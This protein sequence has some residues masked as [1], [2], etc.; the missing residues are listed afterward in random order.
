MKKHI[1]F[2]FDGT[3]WDSF[4]VALK[5]LN[6]CAPYFWYNKIKT[7]EEIQHIRKMSPLEA[8]QYMWVAKRKIPFLA[9]IGKLY[10][11]RHRE[12]I[13]LFDWVPEC[14]KILSQ[15]NQ[16]VYILSSNSRSFIQKFIS[17]ANLTHLIEDIVWSSSILW[18]EKNITKLLKKYWI[19][20]EEAL[21]IWDEVRDAEACKK[22]PVDMIAVWWGFSHPEILDKQSIPVKISRKELTEEI[23]SY[24]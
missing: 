7:E 17:E 10:M 16:K 11:R 6:T 21:Y 12:E 18:K 8:I 24:T 1:I 19:E 3:L 9:F 13:T 22:V 4:S 5:T 15:H 20:K 14:I 2:D 23:L